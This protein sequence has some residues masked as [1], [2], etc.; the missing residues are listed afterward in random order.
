[1][2]QNTNAIDYALKSANTELF[3]M[4]AKDS[5]EPA[6]RNKL[7]KQ[8]IVESSSSELIQHVLDYGYDL[9]YKDEDENSLLH[10]AAMS[11][12]PETVR[13]FIS[14]G[15]DIEA[16]N[17]YGETPIFVAA[18]E[19]D[20]PEVIEAF[21]KAGA[22]INVTCNDGTTLLIIAAGFNPNPE[23]VKYLIKQGFDTEDCD[24]DGLTAL[25]SAAAWQINS[26]VLVA[27]IDA[28]ANIRAK[29]KNGDNLFHMAAYN[30]ST[31]VVHYISSVFS[32]SDT[33][34]DGSTCFERVL[35]CGASPDVLN[36]YLRKMKEEH[37]MYACSNGNAEILEAL[38]L[39]GYD[40][41]TIDSDGMSA[42]MMAAKVNPNPDII[43]MLRYYHA[44]WDN[45][46]DDGRNVLHYAASN[47]NP[48][49]YNWMLQDNDFKRLSSEKDTKGNIPEYYRTHSEEF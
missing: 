35:E 23:I 38:I 14:K 34:N 31:D 11:D 22:N 41:N 8:A 6:S 3:D 49:I 46:D 24:D 10:F 32:T 7:L 43:Q 19:T 39:A 30:E 4:L 33:S 47:T 37:V 9:N 17:K 12:H 29:T 25:L 26:D 2:M 27:L 28:G 16:V 42:M 15:L 40:P 20:N 18:K 13:F 1:M 5:N 36:I 21:I 44:A 45:H 48:K